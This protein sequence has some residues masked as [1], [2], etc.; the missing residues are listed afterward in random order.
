MSLRR[1]VR[2]RRQRVAIGTRAT[3]ASVA[4]VVVEHRA[5]VRTGG[6]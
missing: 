3:S 1:A 6:A 2:R 4:R 5:V